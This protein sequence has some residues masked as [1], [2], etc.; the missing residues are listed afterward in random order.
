MG[1]PSAQRRTAGRILPSRKPGRE[2][3]EG[4]EGLDCGGLIRVVIR[5]RRRAGG[6]PFGAGIG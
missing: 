5:Q 1:T 4:W 6:R 2:A 3:R